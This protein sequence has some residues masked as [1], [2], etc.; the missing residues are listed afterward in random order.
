MFALNN[1]EQKL[2][3]WTPPFPTQP[4]IFF[5]KFPLVH[6]FLIWYASQVS[7]QFPP[8]KNS[9]ELTKSGQRC[10]WSSACRLRIDLIN[11]YLCLSGR[12]RP[13]SISRRADWIRPR[14]QQTKR[15]KEAWAQRSTL[16]SSSHSARLGSET[17]FNKRFVC[18]F[19]R[20]AHSLD[21]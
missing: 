9:R 8:T 10:V 6:N 12:A 3:T 18:Y 11:I 1:C 16:R 17:H 15:K 7:P 13:F 21:A 20:F 5:H 19:N 2:G 4:E 14:E